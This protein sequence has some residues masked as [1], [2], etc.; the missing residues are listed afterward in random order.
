MIF[1]TNDMTVVNISGTVY[2]R[3]PGVAIEIFSVCVELACI[4][5]VFESDASLFVCVYMCVL[6]V[7][8]LA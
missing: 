5:M 7:F 6:C 3:I 4:F 2:F 8:I 1:L